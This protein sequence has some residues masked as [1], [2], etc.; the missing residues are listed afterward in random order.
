MKYRP[1]TSRTGYF[2]S[3]PHSQDERQEY[4]PDK[5]SG[6]SQVVLVN[7]VWLLTASLLYIYIKEAPKSCNESDYCVDI[8]LFT[9]RL[10]SSL[11]K[12]LLSDGHVH[13]FRDW[14]VLW[15]N[16]VISYKYLLG[17]LEFYGLCCS[18]STTASGWWWSLASWKGCGPS[19]LSLISQSIFF[20][21]QKHFKVSVPSVSHV[22]WLRT[23]SGHYTLNEMMWVSF[24][25]EPSPLHMLSNGLVP[26]PIPPMA[27][28][29]ACVGVDNNPFCS[30]ACVFLS[31]Q[32]V[33]DGGT[34]KFSSM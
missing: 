18:L 28:Q 34:G 10:S 6:A 33:D 1:C 26:I 8:S 22:V 29:S 12:S 9:S 16:C 25:P 14:R 19:L 24:F 3:L 4:I 27:A 23:C 15:S 21:L 32:R 13:F 20:N 11:L 17:I 7:V 31:C 30:R 2:L 5:V